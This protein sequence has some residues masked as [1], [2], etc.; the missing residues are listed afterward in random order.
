MKNAVNAFLD[1]LSS[2]K[3]FSPHTV[4]AYKTDL[5]QFAEFLVEQGRTSDLS[6]ISSATK[7]EVRVFLSSLIRHGMSK[8]SVSRKL[9]S[10]RA[11]FGY[12][13]RQQWIAM[14]PTLTQIFPKLDKPLPHFLREQEMMDALD[15]IETESVI[16]VRDKAILELFYGTGIRV[17][18]L[19]NLNLIDVDAAGG[20]VRVVGKGSKERVI[21]LGRRIAETVK[22]YYSR[23]N[24]LKPGP[25]NLALFLNR[26]GKRISRRGVHLLVKKRLQQVSEKK[27]LS[28]H[29]L[30]HTFA[31]H[32]L[33][34]GA[35]LNAVKELLGHS[36]L[37]TTQIYTHLTLDRLKQ[38]YREAHPRAESVD[39]EL[40]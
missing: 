38:V 4:R 24:E 5:E 9:A 20:K 37:S 6:D 34:R 32:L 30:R 1:Y 23:R 10:L 13:L 27:K 7:E 26:S 16:G 15:A 12:A 14:D 33:D 17:S 11:F 25:G 3:Q 39:Q 29:V 36:N 19:V 8:R 40:S 18:E 28:P 22:L 2:E 21:P 35:D 31:T